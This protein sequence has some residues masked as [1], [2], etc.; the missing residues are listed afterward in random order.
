MEDASFIR[1]RS[2][3]LNYR[4]P[5]S[6]TKKIGFKSLRVYTNL[7]NFFLI[8]QDRNRVFDPESSSFGGG[9]A[10]QGQTFYDTPRPRT[11]TFGINA[12]L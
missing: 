12:N 3:N 7:D 8:A 2:L 6:F 1:G 10:G 5:V 9:Y 4:L 11:L